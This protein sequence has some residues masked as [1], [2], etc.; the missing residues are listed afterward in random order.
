MSG[1]L[2][3]LLQK[4]KQDET[5]LAIS[6]NRIADAVQLIPVQPVREE[7]RFFGLWKKKA[8]TGPPLDPAR[9]AAWDILSDKRGPVLE[10]PRGLV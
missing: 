4:S 6:Q 2:E 10:A 5:W 1:N 9:Q 3:T 8:M 7:R